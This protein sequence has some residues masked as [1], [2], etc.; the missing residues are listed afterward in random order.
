MKKGTLLL[1]LMLFSLGS[2]ADNNEALKAVE[3][4]I[5]QL[6]QTLDEK[7]DKIH[8][9]LLKKIQE[10]QDGLSTAINTNKQQTYKDMQAIQDTLSNQINTL[11]KNVYS[12]IEK[13]RNSGS[14]PSTNAT[15]A[16]G[17]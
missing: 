10:T 3:A 8:Q 15:A 7:I 5:H 12:E 13:S 2:Y 9:E 4:Q 16:P 11:Q 6:Q 1:T 14:A 17:T